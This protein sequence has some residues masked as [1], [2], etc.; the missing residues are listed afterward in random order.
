MKQIIN[1][2]LDNDLYKYSM[3]NAVIKKFPDAKVKY[4][5]INRGKHKFPDG[6]GGRLRKEVKKMEKLFLTESEKIWLEKTCPYFDHAFIN[7]LEGYKYDSS[8]IGI[9][10]NGMDLNISIEGYWADTILWEVPVM[11]LIS[12]LY[13]IMTNEKID[14]EYVKTKTVNDKMGLFRLNG[15]HYADF[16]TRRRYSYQNQHDVVKQMTGRIKNS[17]FVGTSN[18]QLAYEFGIKPIGTHAHE[19]FMFHAAKYGYKLANQ[20]AMENWTD[21]YRGDLGIALADTFTSDVFFRSFDKKFAKLYDGVR[22][23][24]GDAIEFATK[25]IEHYKKIGIDPITKVIV[26]SDG[27]NPELAVKIKKFCIGKIMSSFGIGTNFSND[28]G[29]KALNM[30]IKLIETKPNGEEWHDCI[31]LSDDI[32]KHTGREYEIQL[33]K[34]ILN[35]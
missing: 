8:N 12:E 35:I 33:C 21:V 11:A 24:S 13:F 28:V 29:V 17:L 25:V 20:L 26:F 4:K 27:L 30:V 22:H 18:T 7:Y 1:S 34:Q 2:I 19:W 14:D 15:L 23:D 3:M 31:K 9:I 5:F 10:Q 32:G 16:G 6:F